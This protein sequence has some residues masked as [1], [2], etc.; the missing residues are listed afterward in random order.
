MCPCDI[1]KERKAAIAEKIMSALKRREAREIVIGLLFE[2]EF[3]ADENY[4]EIFARSCEE[5][6]IPD[7]LFIKNAYYTIFEKQEEIDECIGKHS[8]GWKISRLSKLS[9]SILRL[10][11]YEMLFEEEIPYSVTINEA[12]ELTKKFDD[13]KARPFVNGILNSV[14]NTLEAD[15]QD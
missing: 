4:V 14:K 5:R 7:D 15:K 3:R 13:E 6:E 1:H 11:V 10:A 9:R 2:S 8:H 12:V